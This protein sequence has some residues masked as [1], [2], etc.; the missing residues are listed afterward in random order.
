M[1]TKIK[2]KPKK[3]KEDK[4]F[5]ELNGTISLVEVINGRK[6]RSQ[7]DGETVL[8]CLMVLLEDALARASSK[9][10]VVPFG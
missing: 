7:L 6:K 2:A 10:Y 3:Q 4:V 8:R 1:K 5:L 9:D